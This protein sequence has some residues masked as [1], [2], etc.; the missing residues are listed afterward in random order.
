MPENTTAVRVLE[1]AQ[2]IHDKLISEARSQ[3]DTITVQAH[4]QAEQIVADANR[5]AHDTVHGINDTVEQQ[6]KT[7]IS[8]QA[9]ETEYRRRLNDLIDQAKKSLA[10]I[11]ESGTTPDDD[12]TDAPVQDVSTS[13]SSDHHNTDHDSQ[14][15]ATTPQ[16]PVAK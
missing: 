13:D 7:L 6:K 2:H 15:D 3:A 1:E 10:S 11:R 12:K 16:P 9:F 8:L 14:G 4:Q 5:Q